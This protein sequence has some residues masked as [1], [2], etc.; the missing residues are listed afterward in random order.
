M[1]RKYEKEEVNESDLTKRCSVR[2][3]LYG[4]QGISIETFSN[5]SNDDQ[6]SGQLSRTVADHKI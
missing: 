2:W 4:W 5:P 1:P 3:N 6:I